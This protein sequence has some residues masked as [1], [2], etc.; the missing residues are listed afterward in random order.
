MEDYWK[1][2][3]CLQTVYR[4]ILREK[5][6]INVIDNHR[7]NCKDKEKSGGGVEFKRG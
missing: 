6:Y 7:K 4:S 1:C 5:D 3:K 2:P